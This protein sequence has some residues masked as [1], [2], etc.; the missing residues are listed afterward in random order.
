MTVIEKVALRHIAEVKGKWSRPL[1]S[2]KDAFWLRLTNIYRFAVTVPEILLVTDPGGRDKVE[3][4]AEKQTFVAF[5]TFQL[6]EAL[7]VNWVKHEFYGAKISS[8]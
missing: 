3:C 5:A 6:S 8:T 2:A 7:S 1:L 4:I